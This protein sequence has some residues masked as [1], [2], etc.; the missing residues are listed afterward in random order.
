MS[1]AV[2]G[3]AAVIVIGI[4][5]AFSIPYQAPQEDSISIPP[6]Q[7]EPI[8]QKVPAPGFEDVPEMIVV[9]EIE[10]ESELIV[11]YEKIEGTNQLRIY[12]T[13]EQ[14]VEDVPVT[15]GVK[16]QLS[17]LIFIAQTFP[18]DSGE[19]SYVVLMEGPLWENTT[20]F[21]VHGIYHIPELHR[22]TGEPEQ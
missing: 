5:I 8:Q 3:I 21:T 13:V 17:E 19:F 11:N 6:T 2:F 18:D 12:G 16:D 14:L 9:S 7:T 4:V 22:E 1:K 15:I 10:T 20:S